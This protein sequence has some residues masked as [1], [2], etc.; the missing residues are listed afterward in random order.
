MRISVVIPVFEDRGEVRNRLAGLRGADEVIVVDSSTQNRV[1]SSDLPGGMRLLRSA[2]AHRAYQQNLGAEVARGE[3]ILFLHADTELPEGALDGVRRALADPE[4]VGGGFVRYFD[5]RSRFLRWTC[6]LAAW[7]SRRWGW[8]LGDQA[9]FV[10][11]DL[12]RRGGGSK[13]L[14]AF[15]DYD[16][17]R[18]LK[19][20][21]RMVCLE[22]PVLSSARRFRREGTCW[23]AFKDLALTVRYLAMG[24]SSFE[25]IQKVE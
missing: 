10:R 14:T 16:L 12:F 19:R 24:P 4:V 22:P 2:R 15:E 21:G 3:A 1:R 13:I 8:F 6:D 18:R 23:R 7:R 20:R 11:R 9:I 5:S 17:C 25:A